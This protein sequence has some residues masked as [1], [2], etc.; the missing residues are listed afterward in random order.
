[1]VSFPAIKYCDHAHRPTGC[2]VVFFWKSYDTAKYQEL[3][4][5]LNGPELTN[6]GHLN[7]EVPCYGP[8]PV[9]ETSPLF[10]N[11]SAT[12]REAEMGD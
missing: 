8:A 5:D 10:D 1:M 7:V 4:L 6:I 3:A 2:A 11:H 9:D 12:A